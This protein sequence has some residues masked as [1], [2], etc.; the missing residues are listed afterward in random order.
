MKYRQLAKLAVVHG[1]EGA[2]A[3]IGRALTKSK[4]TKSK[5]EKISAAYNALE[6]F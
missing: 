4:V 6:D 3:V 2:P 1:H 5:V